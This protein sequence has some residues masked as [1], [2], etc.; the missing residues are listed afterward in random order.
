LHDQTVK[1]FAKELKDFN[2]YISKNNQDVNESQEDIA[3]IE[4]KKFL[5]EKISTKPSIKMFDFFDLIELKNKSF[6]KFKNQVIE[7]DSNECMNVHFV[8]KNSSHYE[9]M[10]SI[11]QISNKKEL[12]NGILIIDDE[13]D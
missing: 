13:A 1:R 4:L 3:L 5:N 11:I 2:Y 8:L 7:N 12:R 9:L 10:K 6:E